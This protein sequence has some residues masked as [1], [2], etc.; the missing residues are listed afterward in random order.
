MHEYLFESGRLDDYLGKVRSTAPRAVEH[1]PAEEV[2]AWRDEEIGLRLAGRYQIEMVDLDRDGFE[3][4]KR[5]V[6]IDVSGDPYRDLFPGRSGPL[7]VKGEYWTLHVPFEG[8]A[9]L[10]E[11]QPSH[12]LMTRFRGSVYK[13]ELRVWFECEARREVDVQTELLG[14]LGKIEQEL[15]NARIDVERFNANLPRDVATAAAR[16]RSEIEKENERLSDH[17]DPERGRASDPTGSHR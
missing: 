13:S 10:F 14:H 4:T 16:R 17:P 3:L 9:K 6:Q 2:T 7:Y 1:L 12:H 5:E 11:L 8:D 15:G